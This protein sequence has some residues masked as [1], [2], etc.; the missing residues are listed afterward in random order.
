MNPLARAVVNAR[1][2]VDF[3]LR[4]A[5]TWSPPAHERAETKDAPDAAEKRWIK[6]YHLAEAR[7]RMTQARWHRNLAVLER[8]ERAGGGPELAALLPDRPVLRVLDVGSKNFDY[9]DALHGFFSHCGGDRKVQ[10]VGVEIDA[11]RRYTD[12]RTRQAW[13]DHYCA[14][15]PGADFVAGDVA[16]VSVAAL[17]QPFDVITWFF[18]FVTEFPLLR[19]G[20]PLKFFSPQELLAAVW[21]RLAPGGVLIVANQNEREAD[22]QRDLLV[23]LGLQPG[24]VQPLTVLRKQS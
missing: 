10:L 15:V 8:L 4:N 22:L 14:Q 9:V 12:L 11:Y 16:D 5:L 18:P 19:W 21:S 7:E 1:N 2:S 24:P 17:A 13:A 23:K 6:T 3:A 20:L